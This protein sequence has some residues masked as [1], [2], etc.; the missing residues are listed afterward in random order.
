MNTGY[1][2]GF[3]G[4]FFH[5][6]NW[7]AG[8]GVLVLAL[9][10]WM[11][12]LRNP[13]RRF[14]HIRISVFLL[15]VCLLIA[16][17]S[18]WEFAQLRQVFVLEVFVIL[19]AAYGLEGLVGLL[20]RMTAAVSKYTVLVIQNRWVEYAIIAALIFIYLP[21]AFNFVA[22]TTQEP[23]F[24]IPAQI[25]SWLEPRLSEDDILLVLTDDPIQ[26]NIISA[27]ISSPRDAI[28]DDRF[29]DQYI[30]S[31]LRVADRA[32]VIPLYESKSGLSPKE[33]DL[34]TQLETVQFTGSSQIVGG[35]NVW[36][37]PG[38]E[39]AG[40]FEHYETGSIIQ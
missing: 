18:P 39:L 1:I 6:L 35:R 32:Y 40:Y 33:L 8:T 9:A 12:A 21:S 26:V 23:K 4:N 38:R 10:G 27:Y 2:F 34:L 30:R 22:S 36:M 25:G 3:A 31:R 7:Q 15:L 19:Y 24:S 16:F 29:E 5:L 11:W 20:F 37:L 28:L 14:S 17:F 13:S